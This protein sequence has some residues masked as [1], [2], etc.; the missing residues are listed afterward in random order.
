MKAHFTKS[1]FRFK[2]IPT[3]I[4]ESV[5]Q[6]LSYPLINA[7]MNTEPF[8]IRFI[9]AAAGTTVTVKTFVIING[10]WQTIR[11]WCFHS[12]ARLSK[13]SYLYFFKCGLRS[14]LWCQG[15]VSRFRIRLPQRLRYHQPVQALLG[16]AK[17][18]GCKRQRSDDFDTL[19]EVMGANS[20]AMGTHAF[21]SQNRQRW[22]V[23]SIGSPQGRRCSSVS[24]SHLGL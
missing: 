14:R 2:I 1:L 18:K 7:T 15:G 19:D 6:R 21:L 22:M 3:F 9:F 5:N 24:L 4:G 20:S 23:L 11:F 10:D 17:K 13:P 12:P 8:S 16:P